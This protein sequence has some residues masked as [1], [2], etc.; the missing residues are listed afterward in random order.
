M[1]TNRKVNIDKLLNQYDVTHMRN[2]LQPINK[3]FAV[4]NM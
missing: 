4:F 2:V 3:F 1:I